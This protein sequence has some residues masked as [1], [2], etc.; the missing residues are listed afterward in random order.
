MAKIG[1]GALGKA[2]QRGVEELRQ[3]N[4]PTQEQQQS[5]E[6]MLN[7]AAKQAPARA[8]PEQGHER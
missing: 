1:E 3:M 5:Y 8:Q 4:M 2:V 7:E 6:Q